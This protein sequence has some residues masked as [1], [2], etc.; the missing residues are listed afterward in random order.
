M[1]THIRELEGKGQGEK[2]VHVAIAFHAEFIR[3]CLK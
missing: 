2:C 3:Y 1:C